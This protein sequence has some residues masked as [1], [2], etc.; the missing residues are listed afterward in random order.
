MVGSAQDEAISKGGV[1]AMDGFSDTRFGINFIQTNISH[2][3]K[4]KLRPS[5][6]G[7]TELNGLTVKLLF[8]HPNR[9]PG[10]LDL[11]AGD[12]VTIHDNSNSQWAFVQHGEKYGFVAVNFLDLPSTVNMIPQ[13][14]SSNSRRASYSPNRTHNISSAATP[15]ITSPSPNTSP[16]RPRVP[17]RRSSCAIQPLNN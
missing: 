7:N 17:P 5:I 4:K 2:L 8:D 6:V 11:S 16:M 15:N 13:K 3:S 14:V 10:E 9:V 1:G 12:S